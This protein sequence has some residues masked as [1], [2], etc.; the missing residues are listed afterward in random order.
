MSPFHAIDRI[1]RF[2]IGHIIRMALLQLALA[3]W[4]DELRRLL[5]DKVRRW[6]GSLRRLV[7]RIFVTVPTVPP[8][9]F[10]KKRRPWNRTQEHI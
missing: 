1:V 3:L 2:L 9:V 6:T 10:R 7:R 8:A 5:P 4:L